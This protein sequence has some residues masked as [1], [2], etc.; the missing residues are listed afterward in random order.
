MFLNNISIYTI[1]VIGIL[2]VIISLTYS[3]T[4]HL[5]SYPLSRRKQE[6]HHS[7]NNHTND[8]H[9]S[10]QVNPLSQ[11]NNYQIKS[12]AISFDDDDD[13]IKLDTSAS[14]FCE[15]DSIELRLDQDLEYDPDLTNEQNN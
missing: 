4:I 7:V 13:L 15:T 6:K 2:F 1:P 14:N 12:T 10:I 8:S 11:L 3:K 9:I 5:F